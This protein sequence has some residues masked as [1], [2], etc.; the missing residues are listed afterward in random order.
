M[1]P[2][3]RGQLQAVNIEVNAIPYDAVPSPS[4]ADDNVW[5]D[6][7]DGGSWVCRD[8]VLLKA[9][10]LRAAGWPPLALTVVECWTETDEYHAVLA[11]EVEGEDWILDSRFPD[12]YPM[13]SPPAPYRW[14]RRQV[15]GTLEFTPV[16]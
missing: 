1:T 4:E 5:K 8:Y 15:A 14:D 3:Q 13:R 10:K 11:V 12:I 7:P 2:E 9:E 16:G 6:A